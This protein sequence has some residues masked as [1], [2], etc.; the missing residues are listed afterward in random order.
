MLKHRDQKHVGSGG[1]SGAIGE[2]FGRAHQHQHFPCMPANIRWYAEAWTRRGGPG[3]R[4]AAGV[5]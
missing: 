5:P 1:N 4:F 3:L 2:A